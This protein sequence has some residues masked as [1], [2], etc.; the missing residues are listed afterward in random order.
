M[1]LHFQVATWE[2]GKIKN[3]KN[4]NLHVQALDANKS[5]LPKTQKSK[6]S[7]FQKFK[8]SK[9]QNFKISKFPRTGLDTH[10]GATKKTKILMTLFSGSWH[11][12]CNHLPWEDGFSHAIW[13]RHGQGVL[14]LGGFDFPSSFL[15]VPW[16]A[17]RKIACRHHG[18]FRMF[19][20]F[21]LNALF[22]LGKTTP[23]TP[24]GFP[25]NVV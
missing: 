8:K 19:F 17:K 18:G 15:R 12:E 13:S 16:K 5:K 11:G 1:F 25:L 21:F 4:Q 6:F 24:S 23:N 3:P 22:S 10:S 14:P 9:N 20:H 7:N 2:N